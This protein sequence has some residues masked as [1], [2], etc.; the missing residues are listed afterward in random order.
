MNR[1]VTTLIFCGAAT[2]LLANGALAQEEFDRKF[3]VDFGGG[4]TPS[5]GATGRHLDGGG[6]VTAGGGFNLNR[7][8]GIVGE[9]QYNGLGVNSTT[10]NLLNVPD[11][12]AHIWSLTAN[13][14]LRFNFTPRFG[15]YLIGG[16]GVYRRTVEFTKPTIDVVNILDPWWGYVGP[17][18]VP[19]NQILGK[20][21][22]TAPGVNIGGGLTFAA[23]KSGAK[24]YV[25]SRYNRAFTS[26]SDTTYVPLTFGIRW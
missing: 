2:L 22:S 10:L 3:N 19:A 8:L 23:G 17:A 24:I 15:V 20:V 25:E 1:T 16:G 21:T 4:Y 26:G 14:T 12:S 5:T 6:N 11:G 18:L 9:F 13:P 7:H